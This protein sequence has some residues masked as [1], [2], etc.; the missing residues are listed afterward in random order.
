MFNDEWWN[1]EHIAWIVILVEDDKSDRRDV[2][3]IV[4][5]EISNPWVSSKEISR[6]QNGPIY[7][8]QAKSA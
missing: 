6:V 8:W 7:L 1:S 4:L 2:C 3:E 5:S